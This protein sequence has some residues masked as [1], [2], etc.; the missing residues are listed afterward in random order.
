MI[1]Y[2]HIILTSLIFF[3]GLT[4]CSSSSPPVSTIP[5]HRDARPALWLVSDAD[6]KIYLFGTVHV[7]KPNTHWQTDKFANAFSAS[8]VLYQEAD[9]S[10]DVQTRLSAS[11]PKLA[12]YPSTQKLFD[13]LDDDQETQIVRVAKRVG[14][15]VKSLNK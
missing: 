4:G 2:L 10:A 9:I 6:T 15:S 5:Q 11:I 7:L 13:V 8:D 1:R 12:F 14:M 3:M